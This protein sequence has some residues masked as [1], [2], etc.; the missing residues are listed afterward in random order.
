[1]NN[2]TDI[3]LFINRDSSSGENGSGNGN[4]AESR[5]LSSLLNEMDG[6]GTAVNQEV[7]VLAATNRLDAIDSALLR[8]VFVTSIYYTLPEEPEV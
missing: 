2:M 4:S 8:K 7:I 5:V 3:L 1:M 6:I